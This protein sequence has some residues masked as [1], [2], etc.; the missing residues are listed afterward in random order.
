MRLKMEN[1][2]PRA[3]FVFFMANFVFFVLFMGIFVIILGDFNMGL[4]NCFTLCGLLS[5]K[6]CLSNFK[7]PFP[8][9]N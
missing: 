7:Q 1:F 6:L 9:K 2:F 4:F 8:F 5:E 3:I